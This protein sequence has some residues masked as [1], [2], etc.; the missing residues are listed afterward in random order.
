MTQT[1][2]RA[3][4]ATATTAD[5]EA[6]LEA[7]RAALGDAA[8][9]GEDTAPHHDR[10]RALED[11]QREAV[12][13]REAR[14]RV[15]ALKQKKDRQSER[16][17]GFKDLE[18]TMHAVQADAINLQKTIQ[19]AGAL[20]TKIK[21]SETTMRR[22]LARLAIMDG[23]DA[24]TFMVLR[25]AEVESALAEAGATP[26]DHFPGTRDVAAVVNQRMQQALSLVQRG[27]V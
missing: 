13:V 6:Q 9:A 2:T 7:E 11:Q 20:V 15:E 21:A 5:I 16:A 8:N 3:P 19:T 27:F 23:A 10:I 26:R 4:K 18:E 1:T 24:A 17:K 14:A 12:A 22:G 25:L